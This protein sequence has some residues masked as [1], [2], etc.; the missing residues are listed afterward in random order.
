M[1]NETLKCSPGK[2]PVVCFAR[3]LEVQTVLSFTYHLVSRKNMLLFSS[4]L[5]K[6]GYSLWTYNNLVLM[7]FKAFLNAT[8]L[9]R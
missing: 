2:S 6:L 3:V 8:R 9:A 4:S 7:K 1:I 5:S